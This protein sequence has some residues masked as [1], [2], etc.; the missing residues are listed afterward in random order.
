MQTDKISAAAERCLASAR[1]LMRPFSHVA[2]FLAE[3]QTDPDWT[4]SEVTEVQTRVI[5]GLMQH[6][7]KGR[8]P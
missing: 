6:S 7:E 5:R 3:L 2:E 8:R 4:E 1:G